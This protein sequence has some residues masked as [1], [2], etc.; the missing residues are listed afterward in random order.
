MVT[1]DYILIGVVILLAILDVVLGVIH[2]KPQSNTQSLEL[3][4]TTE[5]N[6][7]NDDNMKTTMVDSNVESSSDK[8]ESL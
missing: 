4:K 2:L 7:S 5:V 8:E 6:E 3:L 1:I